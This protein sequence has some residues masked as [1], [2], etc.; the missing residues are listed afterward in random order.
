VDK[1]LVLKEILATDFELAD[2]SGFLYYE[3]DDWRTP[4]VK[5]DRFALKFRKAQE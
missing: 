3:A 2:D 1:S 5:T 4:Q